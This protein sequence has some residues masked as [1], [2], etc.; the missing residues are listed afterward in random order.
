MTVAYPQLLVHLEGSIIKIFVCRIPL[1]HLFFSPE[2][3][4]YL[5]YL[6]VD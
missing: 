3:F 6:F 2:A 4:I 5:I 1:I